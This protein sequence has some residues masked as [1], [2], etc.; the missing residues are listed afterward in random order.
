[1]Q[2]EIQQALEELIET[3]SDIT[4]ATRRYKKIKIPRNTERLLQE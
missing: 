1:L 4:K 2:K 3:D